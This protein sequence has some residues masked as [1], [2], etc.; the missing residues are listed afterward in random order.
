MLLYIFLMPFCALYMQAGT[1]LEPPQ[2]T[3]SGTVTDTSGNPLAG[4]NL[5]VESKRIGTISGLDGSFSIQASPSDVL[6]F[7][8][9]GFKPLTV[10]ITG[11]DVVNVQMEEDVTQL[12]HVLLHLYVH[13]IPACYGDGKGF[14]TDHGKDKYIGRRGLNGKGSVQTGNGPDTLG[15]HHKVHPGQG[16]PRSIGDG[17]GNG[18][19]WRFQD[20]ARLHI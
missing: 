20:C 3:V 9:I 2:A 4:V 8:M 13:H 5:V 15:F 16:V 18:G 19:L 7:S 10:P 14:K 12:G 11:R 6:I 1:V 17:T